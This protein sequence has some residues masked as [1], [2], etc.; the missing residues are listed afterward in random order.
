MRARRRR[1]PGMASAAGLLVV[2]MLSACTTQAEPS[3][4]G[5]AG[6]TATTGAGGPAPT[7][8]TTGAIDGAIALGGADSQFSTVFSD[9][10]AAVDANAPARILQ[11]MN[12]VLPFLKD[13]QKNI[14]LLQG[15]PATKTVGDQVA[16]AYATMISGAQATVDAITAGDGKATQ[17]GLLTFFDGST[18][19]ANARPGLADITA[20]ALT[21]K[22]NLTQ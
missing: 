21:M 3:A 19:Y 13:A 12:D 11:V 16:A 8:W 1:L 9:V 20:Q 4:T 6:P 22:K 18:A 5:S 15:Y 7:F 10:S 2:L 14:P 17:A